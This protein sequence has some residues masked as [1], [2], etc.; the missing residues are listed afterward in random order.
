MKNYNEYIVGFDA[1]RIILKENEK[2]TDERKRLYLI[3]EKSTRVFSV[4]E[5]VWPTFVKHR[6]DQFILDMPPEKREKMFPNLDVDQSEPLAPEWIGFN[7][8]F[9][10]N[11]HDLKRYLDLVNPTEE[12]WVT[13]ATIFLTEEMMPT[14]KDY[15]PYIEPTN[16]PNLDSPWIMLGY[17]IADPFRC[18]GLSNCGYRDCDFKQYSREYWAKKLNENHL[19][20]EFDS[21]LAF[22]K[23][24]DKR[25]PEH[26]PFYVYGLYRIEIFG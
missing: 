26:A 24:S 4:D 9:W 19:F 1:R 15:P 16:P 5:N 14:R 20:S 8:P 10:E 7:A 6:L 2:W 17:D 21:A 25:I 23:F 22:S 11:L 3:E 12:I 13:A 18:S